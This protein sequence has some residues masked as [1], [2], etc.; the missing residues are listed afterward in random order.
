MLIVFLYSR[1]LKVFHLKFIHYSSRTSCCFHVELLWRIFI[2]DFLIHSSVF[3]KWY[4]FCTNLSHNI[5][6]TFSDRGLELITTK[7]LALI[8]YSFLIQNTHRVVRE[9]LAV[10]NLNFSR[11]YENIWVSNEFLIRLFNPFL[12]NFEALYY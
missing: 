5:F 9:L 8:F 6:L 2:C 7:L 3:H 1:R 12:W 4:S 10:I 11:L